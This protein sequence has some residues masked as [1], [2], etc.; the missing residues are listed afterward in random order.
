MSHSKNLI[1]IPCYN[2]SSTIKNVIEGIPKK[3]FDD[4]N[5]TLLFI[6][7]G[8]KDNSKYIIKDLI[9]KNNYDCDMINNNQNIG[10]GGVQKLAFHYAIKN[11]FDNI[12]MLHGDN[13][14]SPKELYNFLYYLNSTD[15]AAVFGSRMISY[16]DAYKGGMPLYKIL[17]NIFL[18]CIQNFLLKSNLSEFHSGYRGYRVKYLKEVDFDNFSNYFHFDTEIIINLLEKKLKIFEFAIP[19][20]YGNEVSHLK[21]IPYG[22]N[23]L[24]VTLKSKFKKK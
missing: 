8:S 20:H 6:N 4:Y 14:Y 3:V 15:N 24:K 18:T 2:V 9:N 12:I 22:I 11:K 7:D 10:Y 16:K 21:S 23:V 13:Q 5:S 17:G 1:F 19:T